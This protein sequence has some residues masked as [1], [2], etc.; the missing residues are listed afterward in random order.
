MNAVADNSNGSDS[1]NMFYRKLPR[2]S[3]FHYQCSRQST[4][5]E[6][7]AV[8]EQAVLRQDRVDSKTHRCVVFMDEAGLPEEDRESLKVLH[9]LLEGHMST[10]PTVGFVAITN[11]VLDAAKSNRCI[12]LLRQEPSIDEMTI[13]TTGVL[14]PSRDTSGMR[15]NI[16]GNGVPVSSFVSGLC[17]GYRVLLTEKSDVLYFNTWF[18]LR[19][20]VFFLKAL[21]LCLV[22]HG[23]Q[24][25]VSYED[26]VSALERN[27]NGLDVADFRKVA[28]VFLNA[29]P[30]RTDSFEQ[31]MSHPLDV[32]RRSMYRDD[33][34]AL[35]DRPRYKL[36]IDCSDDDSIL[37]LLKLGRIVEIPAKSLHMLS[38]LP[39]GQ[40]TERLR[41]VSRVK[42]S[43]MKG[44]YAVLSQTE[45]I[46]ESFYDLTNQRFREVEGRN[47]E[48]GL[49]ANI[50][51]GGV[52]RRRLVCA[53][54]KSIYLLTKVPHPAS[55]W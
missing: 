48:V 14:F 41:L 33:S 28:T 15:V 21:K 38:D 1:I 47:G 50:A 19:D 10:K 51:V 43:A 55:V 36:I 23:N 22:L 53:V 27:F 12:T 34:L 2:L 46:N 35:S 26:F 32:L 31:Y 42:I 29:Q 18:G 39:E 8:F 20:F 11:H 9:Y 25:S 54:Q 3:L 24:F 7:S 49:Y 4:S 17:Q 6:I 44:G 37:R 13:I 40:K 52:S 16:G 30:L 45:P 5:K